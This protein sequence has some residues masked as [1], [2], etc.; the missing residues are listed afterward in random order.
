VLRNEILNDKDKGLRNQKMYAVDIRERHFSGNQAPEEELQKR[1]LH[2]ANEMEGMINSGSGDI[3]FVGGGQHAIMRLL[4]KNPNIKVTSLYPTHLNLVVDADGVP[5]PPH[6]LERF[7]Y[8]KET[9]VNNVYD[10]DGETIKEMNKLSGDQIVAM[11][12][13]I[14]DKKV[15]YEKEAELILQ[16][17]KSV[18][19]R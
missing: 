15:K 7:K 16:K 14:Y 18:N 2:M 4:F 3:L 1:D 11:S 6:V 5:N 10:I 13:K 8:A 9:S 17:Q 12:N 19:Q